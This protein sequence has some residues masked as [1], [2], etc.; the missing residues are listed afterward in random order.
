MSKSSLLSSDGLLCVV[1]LHQPLCGEIFLWN[2]NKVLLK[3]NK[4][5]NSRF[6]LMTDLLTGLYNMPIDA[7]S[8]SFVELME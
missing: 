4:K 3:L 6:M 7:S 1:R 8:K 2:V 5:L